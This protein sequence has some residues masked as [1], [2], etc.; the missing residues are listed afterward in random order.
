MVDKPVPAVTAAERF[1]T[2]SAE[3]GAGLSPA[4]EGPDGS[5]DDSKVKIEEVNIPIRDTSESFSDNLE[6]QEEDCMEPNLGPRVDH[7]VE[8]ELLDIKVLERVVEED[9]YG[10]LELYLT[11]SRT[12][13][14]P[15][16]Q[17]TQAMV[18]YFSELQ[19]VDREFYSFSKFGDI[20][21]GSKCIKENRNK[22]S[23]HWG[24]EVLLEFLKHDPFK[25][26]TI[27]PQELFANC[28]FYL[29]ETICFP[30]AY[31]GIKNILFVV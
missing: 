25:Y 13:Q 18:Q 21:K 15:G 17:A 9:G 16:T 29:F 23:L 1:K 31:S 24:R 12:G 7:R 26:F 3:P 14:F 28:I 22:I 5:V 2:E 19:D 20:F 10:L 6:S 30:P 4:S 11:C 8:Q 27:Y